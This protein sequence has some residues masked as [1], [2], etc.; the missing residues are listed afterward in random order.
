MGADLHDRSEGHGL[1]SDHL[2]ESVQQRWRREQEYLASIAMDS[3]SCCLEMKTD[4]AL[5]DTGPVDRSRVDRIRDVMRKSGSW[6]DLPPVRGFFGTVMPFDV[7][8]N[9]TRMVVAGDVGGRFLHLV[10]GGKHRTL[11]ACA[12]GVPLRFLLGFQSSSHAVEFLPE[13]PRNGRARG[14]CSNWPGS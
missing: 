2:M 14:Q 9:W 12:A 5:L 1:Q 3:R 11:A 4:L 10:G 13:S 7:G 8:A 6:G